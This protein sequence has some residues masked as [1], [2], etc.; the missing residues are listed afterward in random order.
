MHSLSSLARLVEEAP[1]E[2]RRAIDRLK[3]MN[4][5][6]SKAHPAKGRF[7]QVF[8]NFQDILRL[9]VN[10]TLCGRPIA[11]FPF[12][13]FNSHD[14]TS[15]HTEPSLPQTNFATKNSSTAS[16][17]L[18]ECVFELLECISELAEDISELSCSW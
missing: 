9:W 16:L 7:G 14:E 5:K 3:D 6:R 11:N 1:L 4:L 18:S 13:H 12:G 17:A 8:D 2:N 15:L 10:S